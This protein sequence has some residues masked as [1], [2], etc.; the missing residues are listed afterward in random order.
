MCVRACACVRVRV[1][2]R[3]CVRVQHRLSRA[4]VSVLHRHVHVPG[5]QTVQRMLRRMQLVV[6]MK[7]TRNSR[8][9]YQPVRHCLLSQLIRSLAHLN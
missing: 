3:V 6:Y 1:R 9:G 4:G 2:V 5:A 7:V 8:H